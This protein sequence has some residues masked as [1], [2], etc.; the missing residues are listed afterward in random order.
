MQNAFYNYIYNET[1]KKRTF[2]ELTFLWLCPFFSVMQSKSIQ[3]YMFFV[4]SNRTI[5]CDLYTK[6]EK[7]ILLIF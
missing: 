3:I 7:I 6:L 2:V 4:F 1:N 5:Q